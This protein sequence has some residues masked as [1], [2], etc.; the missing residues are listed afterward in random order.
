MNETT[1]NNALFDTAHQ[2]VP[3]VGISK[4][5]LG[6]SVR[7]DGGHKL[8]RFIR[9]TLGQFVTFIPV[10]PEV[11]M[12]LPIPREPIRLE[13]HADALPPRLIA[14]KSGTDWTRQMVDYCQKRLDELAHQNLCGYIVQ[15]KSPSCGMQRVKIFLPHQNTPVHLG[16]G[17][18]TAALLR[19]F[20][21]LPVEENGRLNDPGL[22][23]NFIARI[24][25]YQRIRQLFVP[26]WTIG[27]LVKFHSREKYLLLAH[28]E[29][30]YRELGQLV[31]HANDMSQAEL[32]K[33]YPAIFFGGMKKTAT[34]NKHTNVLQHIAGYFK[35]T[36]DTAESAEIQ[37]T[38]AQYYS[39]LVPLVVPITL[40]RHHVRKQRQSY[41]QEQTYLN[42]HPAE[43]MLRN[44]A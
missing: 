31:A 13:Q 23:D 17:L 26:G 18:F 6:H 12:G 19:E 7:N 24:F 2:N 16:T 40:L 22:R 21:F 8:D 41:L 42:P 15:K 30:S 1:K 3:A 34:R 10:C 44:H 9:D 11:E 14:P 37:N 35:N 4:C 20:P 43:L 38:I 39:G 29:K 25:A 5:I 33:S 36:T 28:D 32:E 27:D